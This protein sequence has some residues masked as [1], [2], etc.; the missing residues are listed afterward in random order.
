[1]AAA[2]RWGVSGAFYPE[3]TSFDGP[4]ILPEELVEAFRG[5]FLGH[6]P[7]ETLSTRLRELCRYEHHLRT[8]LYPLEG[9][10]D[11]HIT[12]IS[13]LATTACELALLAWWRYRYTG[14]SDWLRTGA[15]PL[16][17]DT[18]EFY[19]GLAVRGA[20]GNLH[21]YGLN[22]HEDFW[23][24]DDGIWDLSAIRG[25]APLAIAAAEIKPGKWK[26]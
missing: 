14:D 23:A 1:M 25:A 15:Y 19:R 20:D 4:V 2:Q 11:N 5:V 13:H 26:G 18:V 24:A 22:Q 9:R 6:Q 21:L 17:R 16:L 7:A 12:Y 3:T 10:S 8:Q